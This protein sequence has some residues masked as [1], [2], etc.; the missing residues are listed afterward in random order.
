[1]SLWIIQDKKIIMVHSVIC[2]H[3]NENGEEV[4]I[5][6]KDINIIRNIQNPPITTHIS[7]Y[8]SFINYRRI[9]SQYDEVYIIHRKFQN[10]FENL[11]EIMY[12]KLLSKISFKFIKEMMIKSRQLYLVEVPEAKNRI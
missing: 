12:L 1:M 11:K 10:I 5:P 2:Q 3:L 8:S 7:L 6:L 9:A 4:G